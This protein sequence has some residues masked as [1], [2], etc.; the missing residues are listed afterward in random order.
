MSKSITEKR[1][2]LEIKYI[3]EKM[4]DY[5]LFRLDSCEDTNCNC[6]LTET[7]I[8]IKIITPNHNNL[9]MTLLQDYP[10]VSPQFLKING[11]NYKYM[12]KNMPI[13]VKYLY[14]YPDDMYY[15]ES[16]KN[17]N[18][19]IN[20]N[21]TCLCCHSILCSENWSPTIMIYHILQEIKKHNVLKK[22][23]MHKFTLKNLFD[24]KIL[25]FE[26]LRIIYRFLV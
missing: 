3:E 21:C 22:Q 4:P 20:L 8:H 12:L 10:F 9:T 7:N 24:K 11:Y 6:K 23:I 16:V 25:P 2:L 18:S 5:K 14:D 26:L 17:K 19:A 15:Q 13:R 1:L